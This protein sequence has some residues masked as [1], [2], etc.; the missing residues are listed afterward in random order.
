MSKQLPCQNLSQK[1]DTLLV[2]GSLPLEIRN[3]LT[4]SPSLISQRRKKLGIGKFKRGF[5]SGARKKSTGDK[6]QQIR[7]M[8]ASGM[9]YS[10][11][12]KR[13]GTSKQAVQQLIKPKINRVGRCSQCSQFFQ[14]LHA[15]HTDYIMDK[16]QLLCVSCHAFKTKK[17]N[18]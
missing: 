7:Q 3:I 6:P 11:I 1:I 17:T 16:I 13:F 14:H 2:K 18:D 12:A 10:Q 8:K 15:H 9:T 5:V 4:C